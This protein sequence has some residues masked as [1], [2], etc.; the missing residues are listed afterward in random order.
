MQLDPDKRYVLSRP[1]GGL[2]DMLVQL[3]KTYVYAEQ[4][5]RVLIVDTTNSGLREPLDALFEF[6]ENPKIEILIYNDEIAA[7]C[8]L[9]DD[10]QPVEVKHRVSHYRVKWIRKLKRH[11]DVDTMT[12]LTFEMATD[13]PEQLLIH[14]QPGGGTASLRALTRVRLR[15]DVARQIMGR[16]RPLG[17]GYDAIHIRHSDHKTKF[18]R[19]LMFLRP[20]LHNRRVLVCSDSHDAIAAAKKILHPSTQVI[21]VSDIPDTGG[22]PLHSDN[23]VDVHQTNIDLLCDLLAMALA[24]RLFF[25]KVSKR[26]GSRIRYSGFS[27]L[28]EMLRRNPAVVA[29]LMGALPK[30]ERAFL[31]KGPKE[32]ADKARRIQLFAQRLFNR[33]PVQAA[34]KIASGE[35]NLHV[36]KT[37]R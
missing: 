19:F 20:V 17:H 37:Q 34:A 15:P 22:V 5:G 31:S 36:S 32:A 21:S 24:D 4:Y 28:G 29:D 26:F 8:D 9:V 23:T 33:G 13:H 2:N 30:E 3:E 11:V 35:K 14:E 18:A 7:A 6:V 27:L 10:I 12:P 1:R 16:L 25:T